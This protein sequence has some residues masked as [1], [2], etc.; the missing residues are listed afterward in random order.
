MLRVYQKRVSARDHHKTVI[1][2]NSFK[3]PLMWG[4]QQ[5][6]ELTMPTDKT[7]AR[8]RPVL[9]PVRALEKYKHGYIQRHE[10]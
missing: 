1:G 10:P 9:D 4:Y 8:T 5:I 2:A 3:L 6:R 7:R